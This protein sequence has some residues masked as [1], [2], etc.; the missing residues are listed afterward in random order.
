VRTITVDASVPVYEYFE[1]L[2]DTIEVPFNRGSFADW[3]QDPTY[4]NPCPSEFCGVWLFI[5]DAVVTE[6]QGQ[7]GP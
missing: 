2:T 7:L 1:D 5:N 6:M 4:P 3:P